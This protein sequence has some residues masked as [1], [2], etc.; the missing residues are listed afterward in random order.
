MIVL[1]PTIVFEYLG[2]FQ[3]TS[4]YNNGKRRNIIFEFD[5]QGLAYYNQDAGTCK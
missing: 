1:T 4:S 2:V 3:R 5:F